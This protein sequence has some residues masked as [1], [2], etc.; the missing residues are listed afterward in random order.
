MIDRSIAP[1]FTRSIDFQLIQ[2]E[3][4]VLPN[5]A[6]AFFVSGGTQSVIRVELILKA[7][8]WFEST[9]GA[10]Y[11][12]SQLLSKGT[13]KKSS[14]EIAQLFDQYGAH[15]EISPGLDVV[16]ISL[17]TLAK[18]LSPTLSLVRELL[19]D[20]VFSEKEIAQLKT[21]YL[22]NLKVNNEKTSFQASKLFRKKLFGEN[23]PYGKELEAEEVQALTRDQLA[24]HYTTFGKDF[25]ILVSGKI[26]TI[27]RQNIIDEL[28]ALPFVAVAD[29]E[30]KTGTPDTLH[31]RIGK[32]GSVQSSIR[33]GT[34]AIARAHADYASVLFL[35][36]ILGGYF[37]SRLMKNIR[38]EKGL[39]YGIYSSLHTLQQDNYT[40]IGADVNNENLDLTFE[41]I[42]KELK[43]LRTEL[44]DEEEL[45]IARNHF[46]GSLQAEITTPF[47]HADK[48]KNIYLFGVQKDYYQNLINSIDSIQ[49]EELI[50]IAAQYFSEDKFIEVA[51]G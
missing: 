7:G 24:E 3:E 31:E 4:L 23:H 2:P 42:R 33:M 9:W 13:S 18:N 45:E 44:I 12:S 49:R 17:Y 26:D 21:I 48:I 14:F 8:R 41:E 32:K 19:E 6:K 51:V 37:G 50:A 1:A 10:S 29:K 36:H 30:I 35:N 40:V 20:S 47:A 38:E 39:S 5:G 27:S 34:K 22:Q 28:S 43:R 46:I 11:F 15:F 25:T 16:S